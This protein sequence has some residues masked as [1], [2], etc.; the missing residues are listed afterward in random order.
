MWLFCVLFLDRYS[1]Y[2]DIRDAYD[3]YKYAKY[4]E[5]RIN[6]AYEFLWKA[7]NFEKLPL[8]LSWEI[9]SLNDNS[10]YLFEKSYEEWAKTF[11]ISSSLFS[12]ENIKK[13]N[14]FVILNFSNIN[15][16]RQT[17]IY[18]FDGKDI[19]W[20]VLLGS[21][22]MVNKETATYILTQDSFIDVN[23][24]KILMDKYPNSYIIHLPKITNFKYNKDFDY[25]IRIGVA[26]NSDSVR[27][28][29]KKEIIT[30]E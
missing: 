22:F 28:D 18:L 21:N 29:V 6:K 3:N 27:M 26:V 1:K 20:D 11:L 7:S 25:L 10:T 23:I 14:V 16:I 17:T 12:K 9:I 19:I 5:E 13:D 24:L 15:R 4:Y 30:I 8:L 2:R